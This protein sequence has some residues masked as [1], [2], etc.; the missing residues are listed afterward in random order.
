MTLWPAGPAATGDGLFV[1]GDGLCAGDGLCP[2]GLG[3]AI[4]DGE[5][6]VLGLETAATLLVVGV[7]GCWPVRAALVMT[8]PQNTIVT[9]V[10]MTLV[11]CFQLV[12]HVR[13]RPTG[14]QRKHAIAAI[15]PGTPLTGRRGWPSAAGGAAFVRVWIGVA[16]GRT[17]VGDLATTGWS[18]AD[19]TTSGRTSP[20]K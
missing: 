18:E 9:A 16:S 5:C 19:A 11:R 13:I 2:A 20:V 17:G 1:R 7:V 12:S 10:A 14:K 6:K 3:V 15:Q 8:A 4:G